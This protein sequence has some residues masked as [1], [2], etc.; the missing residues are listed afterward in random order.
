MKKILI[1]LLSLGVVLA[2]VIGCS[3]D[4]GPTE[5]N[6]LLTGSTEDPEFVLAQEALFGAEDFSDEMFTWMEF[7][8][9][10]VFG[11]AAQPSGSSAFTAKL[12][13]DTVWVT[14]HEDSEYWYLYFRHDDT[15]WVGDVVQ[16]VTTLRLYDS[17][18]FQHT[19]DPVQWPDSSALTAVVNGVTLLVTTMTGQGNA[20]ATQAVTVAGAAG[21]IANHGDVV[22]DG[23]R[24]FALMLTGEGGQCSVDLE[25]SATADDIAL[26]IAASEE[27]ACPESGNLV[28]VATITIECTGDTAFTFTDT[29]TFD[30]TFFGDSI[31]V[32]A[33][34]ST[35]RWTFTDTCDVVA[36]PTRPYAELF[37]RI[38]ER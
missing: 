21:E 2:L 14:Y 28:H 16:E 36:G 18:Q 20:M 38:R 25:A 19:G 26:N 7:F 30:Q 24:T 22:L 17:I 15:T 8:I 1:L 35:T 12:L 10:S 31:K 3:D 23:T 9:D 4:D 13:A 37:A 5:P 6:E 11:E 27:G 33:E 29:W 34:N 32:V